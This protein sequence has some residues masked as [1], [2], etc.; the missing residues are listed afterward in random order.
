MIVGSPRSGTTLLRLMLDAH[1]ELAIPPET[2]FLLVA[3]QLA[4]ERDS[5][6]ERFFAAV[7]SFP[8]DAPAWGDFGIPAQAFR[9]RLAEIRPFTV[10]EGLRL[11]Y[12]MYAERFNKPRGGDKTPMYCRHL[13]AIQRVLPEARFVHIIRDGRDAAL[14]LRRQWFSP[15]HD[16]QTQALYWRDNVLLARQQ[17]A[18]CRDYLELRY[19]DLVRAPEA[20]LR[21]VCGFLDLAFHSQM[22]RY[23]ES[24]PRRLEEHLGRVRADGTVALA[25][26]Q[27]LLQQ[28]HAMR[29][30]D[31]HRIGRWR[32]G[33]SSE[34][35]RQFEQIAGGLLQDLRYT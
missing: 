29:P 8:A 34:D 1:P 18:G 30:P 15:G 28:A 9:R 22:L 32:K 5:L 12:R 21:R 10:S 27:R 4:D 33:L 25:R 2:G 16:I 23:H 13:Q 6:R 20:E 26:E 19:E 35:C 24:A 17:A 11:F 31:I 7:T 14:S 3:E